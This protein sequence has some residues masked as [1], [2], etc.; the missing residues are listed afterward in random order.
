MKKNVVIIQ[1]YN[2]PYRNELFNSISEYEDIDL[3]LLYVE[4]K[5]ENRKWQD[6]LQTKFKEVQVKCHVKQINYEETRTALSYADLAHKIIV[7]NPDVVIS[8]LNKI[9][10][11]IRYLLFWKKVAL[12]HW[13]EATRITEN[14]VNWFSKGYLKHHLNM[15]Q[16]FL[17]PGRLAK[18]YHEYC[19]FSL[20]DK[21]FYAPNSVDDIYKITEKDLSGK[22]SCTNPVRF[23]FIGS[24]V[25]RKGFHHLNEVVNR[26]K[27]ENHPVEF[28]VAGDGPVRPSENII[29][30]GFV[31]KQEALQL[32]KNS[33]VFLMPSLYDCNPLSL[34]EAA[35][36]GNILIASKGVGNYPELIDGNGFITE[37]D[38]ADSLYDQCVMLL[39]K[40]NGKLL[41]MAK[42][43]IE[44]S[45]NI[46]H[47]NTAGAFH[48]AIQFVTDRSSY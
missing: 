21:T 35:K 2:T 44:I 3:T 46:S 24:F 48:D 45:R 9:T 37:I 14:D 23:L 31:T 41:E 12:I 40:R 39:S 27:Q 42:R 28:H 32:C 22:F 30:H 38:S 15:P 10:I 6:E 16:A 17:F 36:T 13:S 18:E 25:E 26:F 33:H 47:S 4:Q 29:N 1:G 19:G 34:I 5:G 11:L 7:L 8:Q 20:D 43:S